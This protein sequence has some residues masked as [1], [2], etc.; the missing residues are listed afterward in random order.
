MSGKLLTIAIPTFQRLHHLK[1]LLDLICYEVQGLDDSI[2]IF[3]SDNKSNDGT[4]KYLEELASKFKFLSFKIN[5]T[6]IGPEENFRQC[7]IHANSKYFWLLGDDDLPIHGFITQL[8]N[9]LKSE[10]EIDVL[11]LNSKWVNNIDKK[12]NLEI[13]F[14]KSKLMTRDIFVEVVNVWI[15]FI[16]AIII[17]KD[18]VKDKDVEY[19]R[20]MIGSKLI[21]LGWVLPALLNGRSFCAIQSK[22]LLAT[23]NNSGG[24]DA[25]TVF[26]ENFP[27][28][29]QTSLRNYGYLQ[30][31][32]LSSMVLV[33]FTTLVWKIRHQSDD[34]AFVKEYSW[35]QVCENFSGVLYFQILT[36]PAH[37]LPKYFGI[38]FV[39]VAKVLGCIK[40]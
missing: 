24:Y 23:K 17:K 3:V 15:T 11:Y 40:K 16:S 12:N 1:R 32:I 37:Y 25:I 9:L 20:Y 19:L 30:R 21:H 22:C 26:G 36:R 33:F 35:D 8:L 2:E 27:R 4:S 14:L 6:N 39:V 5:A 31:K 34:G 28:I 7:F 38:L 13:N 29:L 10:Q 18:L